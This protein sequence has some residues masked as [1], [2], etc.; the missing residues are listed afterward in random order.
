MT[1]DTNYIIDIIREFA[2]FAAYNKEASRYILL[3]CISLIF[4]S[5]IGLIMLSMVTHD[6]AIKRKYKLYKSDIEEDLEYIITYAENSEL[7][8]F[9][10]G[11]RICRSGVYVSTMLNNILS[12]T[13]DID[14]KSQIVSTISIVYE[15][16]A[17]DKIKIEKVCCGDIS[18][19]TYNQLRNYM[20]QYA[21]G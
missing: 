13:C 4:S 7:K 12:I 20:L 19:K 10:N 17:D 14:A 21:G 1:N 9:E 6:M 18:K 5:I 8:I 3:L 16:Q 15:D 2:A 11:C